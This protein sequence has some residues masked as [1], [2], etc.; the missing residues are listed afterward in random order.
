LEEEGQR[1]NQR[2]IRPQYGMMG[3]AAPWSQG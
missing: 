2:R 1:Q 3:H